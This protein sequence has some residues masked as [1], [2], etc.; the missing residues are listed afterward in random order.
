MRNSTIDRETIKIIPPSEDDHSRTWTNY[1]WN[2]PQ[3]KTL[4]HGDSRKD[5]IFEIRNDATCIYCR[6]K[7][8]EFVLKGS[9]FIRVKK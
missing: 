9:N 2:C 3:C 7:N 5:T 4:V 1:E 6:V 8:G